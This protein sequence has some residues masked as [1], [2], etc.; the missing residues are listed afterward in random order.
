MDTQETCT[1]SLFE[2]VFSCP[3][4]SFSLCLYALLSLSLSV[5]ERVRVSA[6]V[7]TN[8]FVCGVLDMLT[9]LSVYRP[10]Y[11]VAFLVR[12]LTVHSSAQN[13]S[14]AS[15]LN[16]TLHKTEPLL[17]NQASVDPTTW[18]WQ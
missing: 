10:A 15:C 6:S 17:S 9:L 3:F 11:M 1:V 2:L 12:E 16:S 5:R 14:Y 13:L 18:R 7:Y 8:T 4:T